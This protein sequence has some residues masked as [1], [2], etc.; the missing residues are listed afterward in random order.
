MHRALARHGRVSGATPTR[1][2]ISAA[3]PS[4]PL[5][6]VQ[7]F[8]SRTFVNQS[9]AHFLGQVAKPRL[10]IRPNGRGIVVVHL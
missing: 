4:R 10:P 1:Q 2:T 5:A 3:L 9:Y 6:P 8:K 7:A